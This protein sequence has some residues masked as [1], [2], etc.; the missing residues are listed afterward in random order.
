MFSFQHK[1]QYDKVIYSVKQN[2][3]IV[4]NTQLATCFGSNEPSTGQYLTCGHGTFRERTLW[5][6]ILFTN[7]F[8]FKIQVKNLLAN[9]S[10]KIY[11]KTPIGK[12][13][14]KFMLVYTYVVRQ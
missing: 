5:D 6:P 2:T 1:T 10:F 4:I 8:Y 3:Y 13:I 7:H 12:S 11:V 9:V 14:L